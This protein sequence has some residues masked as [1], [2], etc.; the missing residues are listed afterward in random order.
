MGGIISGSDG[1]H[2]ESCANAQ[3]CCS[4]NCEEAV[5]FFPGILELKR[6]SRQENWQL[7]GVEQNTGAPETLSKET[8]FTIVTPPTT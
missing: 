3:S 2:N 1:V 6:S 5:E 7:L 4:L 8:H